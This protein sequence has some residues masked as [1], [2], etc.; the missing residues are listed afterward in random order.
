V[1]TP[2][3]ATVDMSWSVT[4]NQING[5]EY[6]IYVFDDIEMDEGMSSYE[7]DVVWDISGNTL[8]DIEDTGISYEL[9]RD[10]WDTYGAIE[11]NAAV[12]ID[13]LPGQLVLY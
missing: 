4:G 1:V 3:G 6:G 5:F 8:T 2:V 7:Y 12:N 10:D 13:D 11:M 9:S